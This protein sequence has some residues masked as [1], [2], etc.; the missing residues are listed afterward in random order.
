MLFK[1]A[2]P[3]PHSHPGCEVRPTHP[4]GP[5]LVDIAGDALREIIADSGFSREFIDRA[6]RAC[7]WQ[8]STT[9]TTPKEL[10]IHPRRRRDYE[11]Q[12]QTSEAIIYA[13]MTHRMPRFL[14]PAWRFSHTQ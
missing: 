7:R 13:A 6:R 11:Y 10:K 2:G 8:V 14:H 12:P 5:Y 3:P 1:L 9:A 4:G